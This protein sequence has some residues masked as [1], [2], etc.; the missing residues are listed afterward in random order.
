M[1]DIDELLAAADVILGA[2]N[3]QLM[4]CESGVSSFKSSS[5]A[6]L[7]L[8]GLVELKARSHLPVL[9]NPSYA[10]SHDACPRQA[11]A[12][13][14]LGADGLLLEVPLDAAIAESHYSD[15]LR[16]FFI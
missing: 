2:G 7:D 15:T 16:Q 1:A 14:N 5:L 10:V 4:L 3:Q 11:K 13:R 12:V 6:T 8:A 9:V